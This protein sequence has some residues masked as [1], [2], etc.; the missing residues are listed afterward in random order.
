MKSTLES[1]TTLRV[2]LGYG[3][4]PMVDRYYAN[5]PVP[6]TSDSDAAVFRSLLSKQPEFVQQFREATHDGVQGNP[7]AIIPFVGSPFVPAMSARKHIND[8]GERRRMSALSINPALTPVDVVW[9]SQTDSDTVIQQQPQQFVTVNSACNQKA[10]MKQVAPSDDDHPPC[11]DD[12]VIQPHQQSQQSSHQQPI[13]LQPE[14][15]IHQ[16][17]EPQEKTMQLNHQKSSVC[18]IGMEF[19]LGIDTVHVQQQKIQSP[20]SREAL[21]TYSIQNSKGEQHLFSVR[22]KQYITPECVVETATGETSALHYP[23]NVL[24]RGIL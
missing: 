17:L 9:Y 2:L 5:L 14:A 21:N 23:R 13:I 16:S 11:Y 3:F 8:C 7:T 24:L 6:H 19:L 18:P 4:L 1:T 20:I 10:M 15:L 22:R 12:A